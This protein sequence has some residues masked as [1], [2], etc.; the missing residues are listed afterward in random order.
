MSGTSRER[1]RN[2]RFDPGKPYIILDGKVISGVSADD[3]SRTETEKATE[4]S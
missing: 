4:A 2:I 3:T 1:K